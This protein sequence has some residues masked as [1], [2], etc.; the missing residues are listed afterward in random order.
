[1]DKQGTTGSTTAT[2]DRIKNTVLAYSTGI[3]YENSSLNN[4]SIGSSIT[5]V[6]S[7]GSFSGVATNYITLSNV[8]TGLT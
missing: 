8:P 6:L 1:M 3:F 7:S 5:V 2:V 4:G